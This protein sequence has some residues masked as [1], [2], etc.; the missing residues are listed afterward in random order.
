MLREHFWIMMWNQKKYLYNI[1]SRRRRKSNI[2]WLEQRTVY[3]ARES[4]LFHTTCSAYQCL[5]PGTTCMKSFPLLR[6]G[7]RGASC[8]CLPIINI[9]SIKGENCLLLISSN[10]L[11]SMAALWDSYFSVNEFLTQQVWYFPIRRTEP[12]NLIENS[13]SLFPI[14]TEHPF[15]SHRKVSHPVWLHFKL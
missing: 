10:Q 3:L 14:P 7:G 9:T 13:D 1:H 15:T 2:H 4:K 6:T 8:I 12:Q 5:M 11:N